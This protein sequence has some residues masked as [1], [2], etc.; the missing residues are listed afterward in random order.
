MISRVGRD[1]V[2]FM[3]QQRTFLRL[4]QRRLATYSAIEVYIQELR[5]KYHG[6]RKSDNEMYVKRARLTGGQIRTDPP[7]QGKRNCAAS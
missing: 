1:R 2:G 3:S 7:G 4:R 6:A 5:R